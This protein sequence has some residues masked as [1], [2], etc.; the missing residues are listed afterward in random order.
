MGE[1]SVIGVCYVSQTVDIMA[2]PALRDSEH[3]AIHASPGTL[4]AERVAITVVIPTL[5]AAGRLAQSLDSVAWADDVVIVDA[6]SFDETASIAELHGARLLTVRGTTIGKQRNAGIATARHEWILALDADE[7][8][9]PE[10]HASLAR[11]VASDDA[12]HAA[13]RVRSRNWHLGRELR[14]G[15]WGRDWKVRVFKR[16]ARFNDARVHEHL[17]TASNI[18]RLDGALLHWPYDDLGHQITKIA[19]YARWGAEDMHARGRRARARDVMARP[20][21]RFVRDYFLYSGWRD[22]APGFVVA[23]VSA[24]SVF[25]KYASLWFIAD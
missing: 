10:L 8:V 25:L 13:Y 22:G 19:Q 3:A 9:T 23:I 2:H 17:E 4:P 7:T 15:P 20:A 5:N 21:W 1:I 24:F 16:N 11:L 6:G 18:G 14:H 12:T